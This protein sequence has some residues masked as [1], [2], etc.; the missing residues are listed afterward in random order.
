MKISLNEDSSST[1]TECTN[2]T[3]I[4]E[5]F[6]VSISDIPITDKGTTL[7]PFVPFTSSTA[8]LGALHP[9]APQKGIKDTKCDLCG[10][11]YTK[12]GLTKHRNKCLTKPEK[13]LT[14]RN[15]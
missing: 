11:L 10:E 8:P 6:L 14:N 13:H 2:N 12:Q 15:N 5:E 9:I 7:P 1:S 3:D 4:T